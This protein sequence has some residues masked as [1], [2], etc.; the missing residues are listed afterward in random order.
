MKNNLKLINYPLIRFKDEE[1][2]KG[3]Y[4]SSA[5]MQKSF[6]VNESTNTLLIPRNISMNYF[7]KGH[8]LEKKCG[9]LLEILF[10]GLNF[11]AKR[12]IFR[13]PKYFVDVHQSNLFICNELA[14]N[15]FK[16]RVFKRRLLFFSYDRY[17]LDRIALKIKEFKLPDSYTGKGLFS[18]TD[19]YKIKKGKV[20]K[21]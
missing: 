18:R 13:R 6:K 1:I 2:N 19:Q 10:H 15:Q 11:N 14:A 3:T 20:R 16:S 9:F 17:L 4:E 21:K 12:I 8:S 7:F 5:H